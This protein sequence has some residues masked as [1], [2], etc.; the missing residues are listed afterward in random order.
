MMIS[1][2]NPDN[3]EKAE[4]KFTEAEQAFVKAEFD[5]LPPGKQFH[6]ELRKKA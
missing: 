5:K 4:V 2:W 1:K 3:L 6:F